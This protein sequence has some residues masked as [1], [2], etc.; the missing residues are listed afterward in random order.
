MIDFS[1][2]N[3]EKMLDYCDFPAERNISKRRDAYVTEW[4]FET[5]IL[6][7]IAKGRTSTGWCYIEEQQIRYW[8]I[9]TDSTVEHTAQRETEK[10]I[11]T[12]L[13]QKNQR[14][15]FFT[16]F[17]KGGLI[18]MREVVE[19]NGNWKQKSVKD[20]TGICNLKLVNEKAKEFSDMPQHKSPFSQNWLRNAT[21][22]YRKNLLLHR[23]LM[24]FGLGE[25]YPLDVDAIEINNNEI[26]FHEF[27]RKTQC[28]DGCFVAAPPV[29][30]KLL[31]MILD[32]CKKSGA[33]YGPNM[34]VYIDKQLNYKRN[35]HAKCYGLDLSHVSN[36]EYCQRNDIRYRLTLWDSDQYPVKPDIQELFDSDIKPKQ[37]IALNT[38][39]ITTSSFMGFI[40]TGGGNS[41]TFHRN[42]RIQATLELA[43]FQRINITN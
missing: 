13:K 8:F 41:G 36:N 20:V 42:L 33:T 17:E 1:S 19:E 31:L 21:A 37:G 10:L 40:F 32:K 9:I 6:P 7:Q 27:K 34:F 4:Y 26:I 2:V 43:S 16:I 14:Q 28:P 38:A 25:K 30:K 29:N 23:L 12:H 11:I 15:R 24:N 35:E 18:A 5:T 22:G 39:F 3:I